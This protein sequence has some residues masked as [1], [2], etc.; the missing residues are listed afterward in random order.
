MTNISVIGAGTMGNGHCACIC[1][2]RLPVTLID[3]AQPPWT[4]RADHHEKP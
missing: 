4:K 1:P 3:I 2:V